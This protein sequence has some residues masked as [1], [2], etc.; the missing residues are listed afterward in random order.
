M[1]AIKL[2]RPPRTTT[3]TQTHAHARTVW[4]SEQLGQKRDR[5]EEEE[6]EW[7]KK[8]AVGNQERVGTTTGCVLNQQQREEDREERM[9]EDEVKQVKQRGRE[10]D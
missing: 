6:D 9:Y 2:V 4:L 3:H 1:T 7:I 8:I 5:D 10:R